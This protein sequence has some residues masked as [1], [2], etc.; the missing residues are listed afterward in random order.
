MMK[1]VAMIQARMTSSRLPGKIMADVAGQPMLHYVVG[2][3][4]KASTIDLVTVA[5]TDR[6]TDDIVVR[7]CK[8]AGIAVFRGSEQDVLDRYYQ[9]AKSFE[10]DTI[11]RLTAD[12]PLLDPVVIDRV[13]SVFAHGGY[14]YVSNTMERTYPDGLDTEVFRWSALERAWRDACLK[15]EREHVTPFIW[16]QPALFRLGNVKHNQNFSHLRWTVDRPQDLEF[17]R[18]VYDYLGP[19]PTFGMEEI[20]ALLR[21]HPE[22]Q[23][24]NAGIE[25]NEGYATSLREDALINH[26]GAR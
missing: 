12:C 16:K 5:T 17:V 7:F 8:D 26:E 10:A 6:G 13:V 11:V 9:A 3:A 24:I 15:S 2:R 21:G 20:F 23:T 18:R 22:L 1:I 25:S 19:D 14:D 4:L